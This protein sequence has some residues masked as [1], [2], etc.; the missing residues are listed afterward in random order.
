M[1]RQCISGFS[2]TR[3]KRNGYTPVKFSLFEHRQF[4][5][6][7]ASLAPFEKFSTQETMSLGQAL[8]H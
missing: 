7:P 1:Q 4:F 3:V 6:I 8:D 5:L 2:R